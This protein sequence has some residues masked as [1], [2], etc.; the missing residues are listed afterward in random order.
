[1]HFAFSLNW[2]NYKEYAEASE[3]DYYFQNLA[4]YSSGFADLTWTLVWADIRSCHFAR[5]LPDCTCSIGQPAIIRMFLK[6]L[7]TCFWHWDLHNLQCK[8]QW[9]SFWPLENWEPPCD[10]Q[11]PTLVKGLQNANQRS[12]S[13]QER[14]DKGRYAVGIFFGAF[15]FSE[16]K[17]GSFIVLKNHTHSGIW[18]SFNNR[19]YLTK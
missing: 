16:S 8:C 5:I 4:F 9:S 18:S 13:K 17:E 2:G 11:Q 6:I 3:N 19:S 7:Q 10:T 15:K 12:K 14:L 1:M